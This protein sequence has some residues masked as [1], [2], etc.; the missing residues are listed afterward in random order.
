MYYFGLWS[1]KCSLPFCLTWSLLQYDEAGRYSP[2]L[3]D[4]SPQKERGSSEDLLWGLG[5]H[6]FHYDIYPVYLN[7]RAGS[8]DCLRFTD[9]F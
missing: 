3:I 1:F 8:L 4:T 7:F 9:A 2:R 6:D 5:F